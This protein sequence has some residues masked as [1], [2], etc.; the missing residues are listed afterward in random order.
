[1]Q[2]FNYGSLQPA[3]KSSS[4]GASFSRLQFEDTEC[5]VLELSG[6]PQCV[7]TRL[8]PDASAF[9]LI[10][11]TIAL[12]LTVEVPVKCKKVRAMWPDLEK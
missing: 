11:P 2:V 10:I 9:R 4:A 12:K 1:M 7:S 8:K 5:F 6:Q 3:G